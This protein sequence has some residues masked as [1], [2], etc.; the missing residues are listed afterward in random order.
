M[1]A[2]YGSYFEKLEVTLKTNQPILQTFILQIVTVQPSDVRRRIYP[3]IRIRR[4]AVRC[5]ERQ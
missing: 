1:M 4:L 5:A 2:P 3:R